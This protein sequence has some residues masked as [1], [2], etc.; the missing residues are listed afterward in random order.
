M[1]VHVRACVCVCS[2]AE[3]KTI[4][5]GQDIALGRC[6][7][8]VL[9]E[10]I[11]IGTWKLTVNERRKGTGAAIWLPLAIKATGGEFTSE[12]T[13]V[14]FI[15]AGVGYVLLEDIYGRLQERDKRDS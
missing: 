15:G 13:Q 9:P 5:P 10:V 4:N 1:C 12:A 11:H 3:I 8:E 14:T 2:P 7:I 6:A